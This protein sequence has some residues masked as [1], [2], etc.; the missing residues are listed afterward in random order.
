MKEKRI[1]LVIHGEIFPEIP[2]SD[3]TSLGKKQMIEVKKDLPPSPAF[4]ISGTGKRHLQSAEILGL[5]IDCYSELIESGIITM[6]T[7]GIDY[8]LLPRGAL[9]PLD[10]YLKG[11]NYEMESLQ[12]ML[13]A[14]P[15]KT[16]IIGGELTAI[17][18]NHNGPPLPSILLLE[19]QGD[20][21]IMRLS[22]MISY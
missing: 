5:E 4:V 21:K 8:C 19:S 17:R 18:L 10:K 2:D 16:I 1:Y 14:L 11:F 6:N 15:D 13:Q 22:Q 12:T 9:I 7:S 20:S 3:L